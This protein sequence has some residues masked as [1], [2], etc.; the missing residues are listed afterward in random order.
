MWRGKGKT[1]LRSP[2]AVRV[3]WLESSRGIKGIC[4]VDT[5]GLLRTTDD[6]QHGH[7]ETPMTSNKRHAEGPHMLW[8]QRDATWT[9]WGPH[10]SPTCAVDT[11]R[12]HKDVRGDLDHLPIVCAV[13][14]MRH[15]ICQ[16][17]LHYPISM[18]CTDGDT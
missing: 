13:D 1:V 12:R 15:Y 9:P 8:T 4:I 14:I 10:L 7:N 3:G 5:M 16:R 18:L 2:D 17:T 11:V 6:S